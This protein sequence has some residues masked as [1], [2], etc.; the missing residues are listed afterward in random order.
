MLYCGICHSDVHSGTNEFKSCV[1]PFVGG[2]E[3]VGEVAEIGQKV[4]K[5]KIGDKV[6]VGC[7]VDSCTECAHCQKGDEQYCDKGMTGTYNGNRQHGHVSGNP[8][9]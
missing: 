1:Y 7:I 8:E 6:G 2:H 9:S 5:V 4:T 3:L